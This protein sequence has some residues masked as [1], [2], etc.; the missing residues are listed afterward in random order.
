MLSCRVFDSIRRPHCFPI[1]LSPL[2]FAAM[3]RQ[4]LKKAGL[5]AASLLITLIA[6]E[7]ALRL[8][9]YNPP[10]YWRRGRVLF[11][12]LPFIQAS[13]MNSLPERP[14]R[15]GAQTSRSIRRASAVPSHPAIPR[16][17]G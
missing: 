11:C 1:L 16:P 10:T 3:R 14:L 6:L 7:I 17:S 13:S 15:R 4:Y 8:Y 2:P 9:G 12:V 5:S